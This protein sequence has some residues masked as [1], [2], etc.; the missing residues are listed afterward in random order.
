MQTYLR[1]RGRKYSF[2]KRV[3]IEFQHLFLKKEIQV[4]L[5]TDSEKVALQRAHNFN[6]VLEEFWNSIQ[7]S[8]HPEYLNSELEDAIHDAR[9][10]GFKYISK[11]DLVK[12][13]PLHEFVNRINAAY[14][15]PD[16]ATKEYLLGGG[17]NPGALKLTKAKEKYF[18]FQKGNLTEYSEDQVLKWQRPRNRAVSNFI[19]CVGDIE[20][21]QISRDDVLKFRNWWVQR[22]T[23]KSMSANTANK[24]FSII[25]Q[26]ITNANDDYSLDMSV[27]K[28]FKGVRL[29]EK[30]KATRMPFSNSFIKNKFL[31]GK[32]L[33]GLN[34]EARMLVFAMADTGARIKELI[35]L[36]DEDIYL[37]NDIPY[38][39]IRPND[40]RG[41]KTAQS[42]RELPLVGSALFAFQK[43]NGSFNHY[44]GKS[45][46]IS[47][48]INKYFR[49]NNT[50][51]SN[52]HSL[53]SLRHS[54]ED[55]LTAVEP[56]DK[57]QAMLMGHK[58]TRPRYGSGP[59]LA[60][61][62]F[63]LDK[64]AFDIC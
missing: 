43:L 27:D 36:M 6:L 22:I 50:L 25:K 11:E 57:V 26:I 48:T 10:I 28:L 21:D 17:S 63:W 13:A 8:S 9:K 16:K 12:K 3:P 41:L 51:P 34:E 29:K 5:K 40:I 33:S 39:A 44:L 42:E 58:Y 2:R 56:P 15:A 64:I 14:H 23:G 4:P 55:R 47:N 59:T 24:E 18:K 20:I 62:K 60:Q 54:F 35:G 49:E 52:S 19:E 37:K 30:E 32:S 45:D 53:Y 46:L 61:K 31:S 7:D 1:K 38:I